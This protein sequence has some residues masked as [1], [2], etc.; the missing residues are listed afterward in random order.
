MEI[1]EHGGIRKKVGRR[2]RDVRRCTKG[3]AS[4]TVGSE[5]KAAEHRRNPTSGGRKPEVKR[6]GTWWRTIPVSDRARR[7]GQGGCKFQSFLYVSKLGVCE[8]R[9]SGRA[10]NGKQ[11][12]HKHKRLPQHFCFFTAHLPPPHLRGVGGAASEVTTQLSPA[13]HLGR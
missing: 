9:A 10:A 13:I 3:G 1:G 8:R 4:G 12:P 2:E 7:F 5:E 6:R 11:E